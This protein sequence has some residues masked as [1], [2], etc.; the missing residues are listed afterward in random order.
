MPAWLFQK[1]ECQC[2]CRRGL[3]SGTTIFFCA[4]SR[5][6]Q[7]LTKL[8][9]WSKARICMWHYPAISVLNNRPTVHN[10][11]R[12]ALRFLCASMGFT[13]AAS[14]NASP[15]ARPIDMYPPAA[16][17]TGSSTGTIPGPGRHRQ[18]WIVLVIGTCR[19]RK[20][21]QQGNGTRAYAWQN[22]TF[23]MSAA[24]ASLV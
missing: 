4:V 16:A 3:Y 1:H 17:S 22:F 8:L 19:C 23:R 20:C 15:A 5:G 7:K 14:G 13:D 10:H 21:W 9:T 18:H 11:V 24:S 6:H 2:A 12:V